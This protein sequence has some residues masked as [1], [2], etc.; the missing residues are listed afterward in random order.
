M[1]LLAPAIVIV[2]AL[3]GAVQQPAASSPHS[4]TPAPAAQELAGPQPA[5]PPA[6]A[7]AET[8]PSPRPITV[9]AGTKVTLASTAPLWAKTVKAGD[10][11]YCVTTFPVAL[12]NQMVIPPGT[13]VEGQIDAL[14]KPGWFSPHAQFQMHFTKLIFANGYTV[15]LPAA[16]GD[17]SGLASPAPTAGQGTAIADVY[18]EVS[19]ASDLLLDTGSQFDMVLQSPA[20]LDPN[21]VADA[22]L[23]AKPVAIGPFRSSTLC[24]PTPGSPGTSDTVIPGTPATPST[25]IPGAPGT[26]DIVIPG[27][28]GTSPTVI[29]GSPGSPGTACPEPPIVTS[30][31]PGSSKIPN[32][33]DWHKAYTESFSLATAARVAGKSLPVGN[34]QIIWSG[35]PVTDVQILQNGKRVVKARAQI[36][37]LPQK[38]QQD[39]SRTR[40]SANGAPS[41]DVLQFAGES[42]VVMF[43]E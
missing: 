15:E 8:R 35:G 5:V 12:D 2:A 34:Y 31:P 14:S 9:P 23:R 33:P 25:V 6:N 17:A 7:R 4:I 20:I 24:R 28:P 43:V 41:L 3:A 27:S 21:R 30:K 16:P 40:A 11:V 37:F 39:E 38:A 19:A 42:V 10:R 13:Y 1:R 32:P 22:T 29:P 18:V 26:P 36:R